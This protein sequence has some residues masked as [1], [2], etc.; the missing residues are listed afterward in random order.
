MIEMLNHVTAYS[1]DSKGKPEVVRKQEIIITTHSPFVI[2][3]SMRED[4]Y[5]FDKVK[6]EVIYINPKIETYG[7]SVS[8]LL[9]EIFDRRISISD[10]SNFDLD[11]LRES[12]KELKTPEAIKAKIEET[13]AK[14]VSFGESIEKFDLY[15]LLRQ[16]EKE[17]GNNT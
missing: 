16:I 13:K 1:F 3:D 14:L 4:V 7:A 10:L 11:E 8:L 15:S 17:L 6:G 9:Q 5:K 2:S 12:L